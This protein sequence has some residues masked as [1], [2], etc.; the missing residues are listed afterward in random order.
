MYSTD[1]CMYV[2]TRDC[3]VYGKRDEDTDEQSRVAVQDEH[4]GTKSEPRHHRHILRPVH[5]GTV[6]IYMDICIALI[7]FVHFCSFDGH[8]NR[9]YVWCD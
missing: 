6:Y 1:V 3:C 7:T 2:C 8:T 4:T 5:T 9:M